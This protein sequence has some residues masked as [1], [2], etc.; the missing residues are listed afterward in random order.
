M[1]ELA[2]E[3][4]GAMD[5]GTY[6]ELRGIHPD[7]W[8][9]DVLESKGKRT[10]I[11]CARQ[12]GKTTIVGLLARHMAERIPDALI[13][14]VAPTF[15]QALVLFRQVKQLTLDRQQQGIVRDSA[16]E[17]ELSNGSR[18]VALPGKDDTIRGFPGVTMIVMDEAAYIPDRIYSAVRPMVAVSGGSIVL[19]S[20]PRARQGFFWNVWDEGAG[21]EN[22]RVTAA[23]CPRIPPEEIEAARDELPR[24]AFRREYM[25]EFTEPE[26]SLF[27]YE[28]VQRAFRPITPLFEPEEQITLI[29]KGLAPLE[30]V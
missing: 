7:P 18:M 16:T 29:G 4:I 13:L 8:Q 21:W 1:S 23:E 3:L 19:L 26:E 20:T 6:A 5:A 30:V 9:R 11:C 17:L 10:I 24:F 12:T 14:V 28:D 22:Y 2:D 15:R 25:A 27:D